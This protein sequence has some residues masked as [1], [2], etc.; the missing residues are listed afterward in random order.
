MSMWSNGFLDFKISP[1][2]MGFEREKSNISAV[3]C[4]GGGGYVAG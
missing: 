4:A 1:F 3:I 2:L